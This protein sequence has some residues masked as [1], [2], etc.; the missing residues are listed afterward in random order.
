MDGATTFEKPG[1]FGSG[2]TTRQYEDFHDPQHKQ[3]RY[4]RTCYVMDA[5][6]MVKAYVYD[7]VE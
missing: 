3:F 6:G 5:G 2:V 1:S 4:K 7:Y